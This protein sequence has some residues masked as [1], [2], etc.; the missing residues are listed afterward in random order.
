M[1]R[2]LFLGLPLLAAVLLI[3]FLL[4]ARPQEAAPILQAQPPQRAVAVTFDDLPAVAVPPGLACDA[5][6]LLAFTDRL[7]ASVAA[8]GVP[9]TGLGARSLA[10]ELT[11]SFA[12][13]SFPFQMLHIDRT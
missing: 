4:P 12:P 2:F 6:A 11:F 1:K 10:R 13:L 7:L 9:A 3:A 8:H 5:E